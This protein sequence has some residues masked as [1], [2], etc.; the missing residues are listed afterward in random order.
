MFIPYIT[1]PF[2]GS[3]GLLVRHPAGLS[4]ITSYCL[5]ELDA[6]NL[7]SVVG[8]MGCRGVEGIPVS[9]LSFAIEPART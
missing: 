7:S 8:S 6:L 3:G 9:T 4:Q 1:Q 5:P 2:H